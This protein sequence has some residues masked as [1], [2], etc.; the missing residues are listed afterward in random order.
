MGSL[1]SDVPGYQKTHPLPRYGTDLIDR[2]LKLHQLPSALCP[3]TKT[4]S[5]V[6]MKAHPNPNLFLSGCEL[7]SFTERY[8]DVFMKSDRTK[9]TI[10]TQTRTV[11]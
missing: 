11:N 5:Y 8:G 3:T 4:A 2:E 6:R 7:P 1:R 9:Q 10:K